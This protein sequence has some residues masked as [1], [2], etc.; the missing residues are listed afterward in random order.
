RDRVHHR[1]AD[2]RNQI[3]GARATCDQRDAHLAG[4]LRISLGGVTAAGLVPD[5][6]VADA[7]V[8]EGVVRRE[9]GTARQP[10]YDVDPFRLEALH[11]G[12]D[13]AHWTY[14]PPLTCSGTRNRL[15]GAGGSGECTAG[16][17]RRGALVLE[18]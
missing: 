16:G 1:V 11:Q 13:C 2:R 8:V 5:Q 9:V 14:S 18:W 17:C 6:D 4:R 3:R 15:P 7:R 12:V 10:E